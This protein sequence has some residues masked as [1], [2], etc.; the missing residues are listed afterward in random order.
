M[1]D[2]FD[3]L[4]QPA[5]DSSPTDKIEALRAEVAKHQRLYHTQDAP[6]IDDAAY[7]Q[8]V[9]ELRQLEEDNG[10]IDSTNSPSQAVGAAPSA[11]FEPVAHAKP[12][13][14]LENVF[15]E[16]G[17]AARITSQRSFLNMPEHEKLQIL[18]ELKFDGLSLSLRYENGALVSAATRGDG[19]VGENVTANALHVAG[20]PKTLNAPFPAVAEVR[21]EVVM[22]K[23]TFLHINETG[24]A[25]RTFT[26]P[27]NAAAG[28]LRQKDASKTAGR[29]LEF[30]PHGVGEWS[31][32]LP[33]TMTETMILVER[34]GFGRA[35]EG[36]RRAKTVSGDPAEIAAE[37]EA[38]SLE[39]S[40]LPFDIDGV[41]MKIDSRIL[42]ERLGEISRT[43]RWATAIKFPAEKATTRI[44]NIDIQIGRTGRATPVARLEPVNVGGV[45]VS[46]VT[47]HNRDY[48]AN[49]DL[50]IGDTVVIQR[51]GDVIPQIVE[52]LD[53]GK[54]R[55]ATPWE[56]PANCPVCKSRIS[57]AD[58]EAD[59]YCLGSF[60]CSAQIVTRL[61]HISSRDALDIDGLGIKAIEEMHSIGVLEKPADIFTLHRHRSA[62]IIRD[63]WGATS[64]DKLLASIDAARTCTADRALYSLG[65]RHC[66]RS[67][68]KALAL[69]WG[70]IENIVTAISD[71]SDFRDNEYAHAYDEGLSDKEA[72][73]QALKKLAE[74]VG[75]PD[76]GPAVLGN[77]LD[78]FEDLSDSITAS[79]LFEQL[80]VKPLEKAATTESPVTGKT[81][82]FTG[83]LVEIGR[84]EAKAQAER[85][86]AK[87]SGSVSKKTDLVVA[88]P[89][90]GSKLKKAQELG[91]EVI[92]EAAW[93]AIVRSVDE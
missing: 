14:S 54:E 37:Y 32:P 17:I 8:M 45:I 77:L 65:I 84:E 23:E 24:S 74:H 4:T 83:S 59:S 80:D 27:R 91:I 36:L 41:V 85:L 38:I 86:G 16:E 6:E 15:D 69:E 90:A 79:D 5:S 9:K 93:L 52:N 29:G 60:S 30:F 26:N 20:I 33:D 18:L 76:I 78:F 2:L 53:K 3:A 25:G 40:S 61:A 71:L 51:A 56:M 12:M 13:L 19:A 28:S 58:E 50:R 63:G 39:R 66:G 44:Q 68:T 64:V 21:G 46:N 82:V 31:E 57:K 72:N 10:N 73:A 70:N 75:I 42:R 67:A 62:L 47:C 92:D 48:I 49:L 55:I 7:D 35:A 22:P 87:A 34:L 88:G 43:P 89:G 81:I 1:A 11:T